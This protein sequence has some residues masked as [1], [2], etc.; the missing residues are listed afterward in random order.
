MKYFEIVEPL[1]KWYEKNARILPWRKNP[2]PYR[3]WISEIMLQQTRVE[4]V[5]PYFERFLRE[6]PDVK[7]LAAVPDDRLMKLWEGLGYYSRARSLKKAA[8]MIVNELGGRLPQS[9]EKLKKLPGIGDYTAGAIAS[10]ACGLPEPAVDGNVLRVAARLQASPREIA[11][12]AAKADLREALRKVY[13]QGKAGAFTQSLMELGA[14]VCLPNGE[15]LCRKCPLAGLCE[16]HRTGRETEFPVK[17]PKPARRKEEKTVFVLLCGGKTALRKRPPSGLLAGM[18]EFPNTEGALSPEQAADY[19]RKQGVSI[20]G[21]EPL[22][23][24]KHIFSHVEWHMTEYLART[25]RESG[26]FVW[27]RGPELTGEYAVPSAFR[28]CRKALAALPEMRK[29]EQS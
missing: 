11:E 4:A 5:I 19:L 15:P 16:A 28:S 7:A 18:W 8:D 25:E 12:P 6:L 26:G 20:C 23:G 17:K 10:I 3:V 9:A 29:E 21:I 22:P 14:T 27:A 1:L 2:T 24:A 13:P